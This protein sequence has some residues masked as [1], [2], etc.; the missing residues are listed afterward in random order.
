MELTNEHYQ[1]LK[2][3][4][5]FKEIY[6]FYKKKVKQVNMLKTQVVEKRLISKIQNAMNIPLL[7]PKKM[8]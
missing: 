2:P 1:Y 8:M 7:Q 5:L 6:S 3:K 4:A